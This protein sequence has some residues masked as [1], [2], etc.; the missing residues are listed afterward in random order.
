MSRYQV[1]AR[2]VV[3]DEG[4]ERKATVSR[5][6]GEKYGYEE[7]KCVITIEGAGIK[8]ARFLSVLGFREVEIS[9]ITRRLVRLRLDIGHV[10]GV[11]A[12]YDAERDR[13]VYCESISYSNDAN[14]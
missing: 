7:Q 13:L 4:H 9:W 14:P 11:E 8:R 10:A 5:T 1:E 12:V 6:R 2:V 3:W